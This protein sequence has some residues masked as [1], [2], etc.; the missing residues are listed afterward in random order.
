MGQ[1]AFTS[2][3][4]VVRRVTVRRIEDVTPRMRRIVIGGEGLGEIVVDGHV[5][6]GFAAPGF[7]DH[8][9]LIFA[10]DGDL[11]SALPTQLPHG[12]EWTAAEN[13]LARDYT[14]RWVDTEASELALDF[15]LHGDGPA[16]SWAQ[17]AAIGDLLA[18]VGPKSSLRLPEGIDW[19]VLV[20]DE[21]G[22]PAVGRFLDERP[23]D[24]P[25]YIVL[26]VED[27]SAKQKLNLRQGDT[28]VWRTATA[29]DAEA[30]EEAVRALPLPDAGEGYVWAGAESRSL[31]PVRRYLQRE[32]GFAKDRINATGYW[33]AEDARREDAAADDALP[34]VKAPAS[35]VPWL[36]IRAAIQL[37]VVDAL[38]D[39]AL[40]RRELAD[41]LDVAETSVAALLDVL[42][43]HEVV[44]GDAES[45]SLGRAGE[46]LLDEH[47]REE[48]VGLE[49]E[50][51]VALSGLADATRGGHS[52]WQRTHGATLAEQ[53][54]LDGAHVEE[55]IENAGRLAYLLDG[56]IG[57]E[58]W[59]SI[60]S[61]LVVGPGAAAVVG[62]LEDGGRSRIDIQAHEHGRLRDGILADLEHD[63]VVVWDGGPVDIAVLGLALAHRTDSE[64]T[65]LLEE[66]R[67]H[68]A[69]AVVLE[70]S[71]PDE[72]SVDVE[73]RQII[74]D[75]MTGAAFRD[76]RALRELAAGAGWS[77][78]S[79]I[80]LGWG[81]AAT[82]LVR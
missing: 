65:K 64:A 63:G 34:R 60:A 41:G 28:I 81:M 7:D 69:R 74:G 51:V 29:G 30:M 70:A 40:T 49:A 43:A 44:V 78:E 15:V 47:H 9:K 32:R 53:A 68:V 76:G 17:S 35:P 79:V 61:L 21:T 38:A 80:P 13:R 11:E 57:N 23:V 58:M 18:F 45:L 20:A 50:A 2:H 26:L 75:A 56:L 33:H 48:F 22:L 77:L 66:L 8:V 72:L 12:I 3:P 55:L 27:E 25:A 82:V 5:H 37:G 54:R 14:P 39:G 16:A 31:L 52:A 46:E 36:V 67:P 59:N 4:L 19:V 6:R 10:A 42:A 62:A 1:R 73:E 24:V 71:H